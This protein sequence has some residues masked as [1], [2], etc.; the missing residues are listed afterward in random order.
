MAWDTQMPVS[1]PLHGPAQHQAKSKLT[2]HRTV[3]SDES[4]TTHQLRGPNKRRWLGPVKLHLTF[5]KAIST[6]Q[7]SPVILREL[8]T[9]LSR[10]KKK[11]VVPT[12]SRSTAPDGGAGAPQ[13]PTGQLAGK[14]KPNKL[15]SSGDSA[16]PANRRPAPSEECAPLP[17]SAPA[18]TGEQAASCSRQLGSPEGGATYATLLTGPVAPF[19]QVG[20]SSPHP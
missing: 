9:A 17:A 6:L 5:I 10:R 19:R 20:S 18:V 11:P 12:G 7:L 13:R 15:A 8:R 1:G 3:Y 14:R 2:K 4:Q 16:E